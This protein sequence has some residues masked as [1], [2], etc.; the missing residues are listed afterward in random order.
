LLRLVWEVPF[1]NDKDSARE[2][3]SPGLLVDKHQCESICLLKKTKKD[4]NRTKLAKVVNQASTDHNDTPDEHNGG[5]I[6]RRFGK[7]VKDHVAR[8]LGQNVWLC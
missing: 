1:R 2:E 6:L 8:N 5:H 7:L 3:T 4:S